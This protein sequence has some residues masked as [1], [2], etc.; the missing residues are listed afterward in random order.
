[1]LRPIDAPELQET[2]R[3]HRKRLICCCDATVWPSATDQAQHS[4]A[5]PMNCSTS[6]LPARRASGDETTFGDLFQLTGVMAAIAGRRAT[7]D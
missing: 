5:P 3:V 1:M 6:S 4:L 2:S 7:G